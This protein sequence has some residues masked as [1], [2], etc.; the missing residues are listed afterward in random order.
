MLSILVPD[1]KDLCPVGD[2]ARDLVLKELEFHLGAVRTIRRARFAGIVGK[3]G[4]FSCDMI[5]TMQR[6]DARG[7]R[8]WGGS[9]FD[10]WAALKRL[11]VIE[12]PDSLEHGLGQEEPTGPTKPMKHNR[13]Q[14]PR[15]MGLFAFLRGSRRYFFHPDFLSVMEA[16]TTGGSEDVEIAGKIELVTPEL[17]RVLKEWDGKR[18]LMGVF[19]GPMNP[20]NVDPD[21]IPRWLAFLAR[22]CDRLI[23]EEKSQVVLFYQGEE[24]MRAARIFRGF[25]RIKPMV[26]QVDPLAFSERLKLFQLCKLVVVTGR[27]GEI[28]SVASGVPP[29]CYGYES[30]LSFPGES[31]LSW[32]LNTGGEPV[33]IIR[34]A[35]AD[36]EIRQK[37]S[38]EMR[39]ARGE[40]KAEM[41]RWVRR[42]LVREGFGGCLVN[43]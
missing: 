14:R 41:R 20:K 10:A 15:R 12:L 30:Q 28:I 18:Q 34:A 8:R 21:A 40:T 26:I 43:G 35:G 29:V 31:V 9:L 38:Y 32:P 6:R 2:V 17:G 36:S 33:H 25:S 19:L 16:E 37:I 4:A 3:R 22:T 11:P 7:G 24:G 1:E 42:L 27:A 13:S 5:M 39:R 23:Y